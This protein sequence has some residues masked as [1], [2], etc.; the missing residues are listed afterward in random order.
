MEECDPG[1]VVLS[2]AAPRRDRLC[3]AGD[4]GTRPDNARRRVDHQPVIQLD[5]WH[6]GFLICLALTFF[7]LWFFKLRQNR[8]DGREDILSWLR[9]LGGI[10]GIFV[11]IFAL[12]KLTGH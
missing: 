7:A 5:Y 11:G 3:I 10:A 8:P 1:I 6:T 4:I 2:G 12:L 9:A